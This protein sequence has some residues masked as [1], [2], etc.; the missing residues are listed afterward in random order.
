MY[1]KFAAIARGLDRDTDY[2]VDEE[3]KIIFP[4]PP[5]IA[6]VEQSLG[7]D[8]LYDDVQTSLVH[9]LNAAIRA[10]ELYRR[11]RDYVVDSGEVKIVGAVYDIKTAT[12][13]LL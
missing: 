13:T 3:K 8:N 12:V 6:K 2:E 4:L 7:V 9:Q 1:Y 10:K 11:D 5:G